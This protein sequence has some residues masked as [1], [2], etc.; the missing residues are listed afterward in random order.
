MISIF[1]AHADPAEPGTYYDHSVAANGVR[2][3]YEYLY[4]NEETLI[5]LDGNCYRSQQDIDLW[6]YDDNNNLVG[7][8]TS[9]GC[10]EQVSI[11]PKWSATFKIVVENKGKPYRT[12]YDLSMF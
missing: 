1:N 8:A 3:Y 10:Y 11:T 12:N 6:L 9:S 2:T 4:A 7:K 5:T